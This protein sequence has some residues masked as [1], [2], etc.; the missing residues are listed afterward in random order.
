MKDS[1]D[2]EYKALIDKQT[3]EVVVPPKNVNIVRNK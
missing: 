3:W 1:M 2:N